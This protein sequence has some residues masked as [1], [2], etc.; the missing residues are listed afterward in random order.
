MLELC[1]QGTALDKLPKLYFRR[2]RGKSRDNLINAY[3]TS[4]SNRAVPD[5]TA[6]VG[7]VEEITARDAFFRH[8]G[9]PL[10]KFDMLDLWLHLSRVYS[11]S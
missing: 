8:R 7:A 3:V 6:E 10:G 4:E 2:R 1:N 5:R 9:A 11:T